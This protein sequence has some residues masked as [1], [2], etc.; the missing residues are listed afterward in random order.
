MLY[1]LIRDKY[2]YIKST[3]SFVA[4]IS[5]L[6]VILLFQFSFKTWYIKVICSKYQNTNLDRFPNLVW[7]CPYN[8][9]SFNFLR[10]LDALHLWNQVS[11]ESVH[12]P[13]FEEKCCGLVETLPESYR[14]LCLFKIMHRR[15]QNIHGQF[16]YRVEFSAT[17]LL[18]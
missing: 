3:K 4:V 12:H 16:L 13:R 17:L 2:N 11:Q 15:S 14:R 9:I 7:A 6:W 1:F 5:I 18:I 10:N 8:L